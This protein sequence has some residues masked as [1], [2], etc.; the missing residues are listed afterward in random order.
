MTIPASDTSLQTVPG[1]LTAYRIASVFDAVPDLA[2]YRDRW[3]R[4]CAWYQLQ[5]SYW[6]GDVY[7]NA[8]LRQALQLYAGVRQIFGPLRRAVSV[9]EALVAGVGEH[10][11]HRAAVVGRRLAAHQTGAH[12][13]VE[14]A[15]EP[16]R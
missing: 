3:V 12:Q 15:G 7:S 4:R 10:G 13:A 2:I 5:R 6:R 11:Q 14:A 1:Y 16:A 9:D 8:T